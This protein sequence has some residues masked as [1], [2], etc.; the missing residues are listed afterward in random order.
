MS[1]LIPSS[2]FKTVFGNRLRKFMNEYI[3]QIKDYTREKIF[4]EALVKSAIIVF[5]KKLTNRKVS[6]LDMSSKNKLSI[7]KS[8]MNGKWIFSN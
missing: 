2:I 6:Y 4:D 8:K 5:D 1:Y 7:L 3:Y